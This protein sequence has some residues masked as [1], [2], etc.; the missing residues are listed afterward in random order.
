MSRCPSCGAE[1]P[2]G[3]VTCSFCEADLLAEGPLAFDLGPEAGS[4]PLTDDAFGEELF[5]VWQLYE[6]GDLDQA[7]ARGSAMVKTNPDSTSALSVVALIYE[8][9][10][11]K[12]LA[13]GQTESARD[14][15]KLAKDQYDRI[16]DLNPDSAADR[17]KLAA[18]MGKLEGMSG[19]VKRPVKSSSQE[20]FLNSI[21]I[22]ALVGAVAF[23]AIIIVLALII[24]MGGSS[25]GPNESVATQVA[26]IDSDYGAP[27]SSSEEDALPAMGE[28]ENAAEE[29]SSDGATT[30]EEPAAEEE[31]DTEE[32]ERPEKITMPPS[33]VPVV[34]YD[35]DI[36][37]VPSQDVE[38]PKVS[39]KK[40]EETRPAPP[41]PKSAPKPA[42]KPEPPKEPEKSEPTTP[43]E[44]EKTK[45]EPGDGDSS[46]AKAI[47]KHG[48]GSKKEAVAAAQKALQQYKRVMNSPGASSSEKNAAKRGAN[49]AESYI[50][51]WKE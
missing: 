30:D 10:A 17:D 38:R 19:P 32:T 47:R 31:S 13:K 5:D 27:I 51:D 35:V 20:S 9:K 34:P 12:E 43:K 8:R 23:I 48:E 21:P 29:E 7:L 24:P 42:E 28:E 49:I 25:Q 3:S 37:V 36:K 40:T 6:A 39:V 50:E 11:E 1:N 45:V 44:P 41:K 33:S 2:T 4:S 46:L 26:D 16:V 14:F 15:L 22:P 18:I